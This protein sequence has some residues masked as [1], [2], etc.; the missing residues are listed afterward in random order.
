MIKT[1]GGGI[2]AVKSERVFYR[3]GGEERVTRGE[4][5]ISHLA[6]QDKHLSP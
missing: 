5:C 2:G 6:G 3:K 4:R 1:E